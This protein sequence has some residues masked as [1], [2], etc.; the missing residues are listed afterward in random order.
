DN[1][2]SSLSR[3]HIVKRFTSW[4]TSGPRAT[5]SKASSFDNL[6]GGIHREYHNCNG[7]N[8]GW[9]NLYVEYR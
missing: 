3:G 7:N 4:S 9:R 8:W 5:S 2:I 1:P 6:S